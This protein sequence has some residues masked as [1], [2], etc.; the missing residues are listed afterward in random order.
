[1]VT[2]TRVGTTEAWVFKVGVFQGNP[3]APRIYHQQEDL[4]MQEVGATISGMAP[5]ATPAGPIT[6]GPERYPDG[7]VIPASGTAALTTIFD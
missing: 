2:L 4:Y 5:L 1:M 3:L 7:E 6:F